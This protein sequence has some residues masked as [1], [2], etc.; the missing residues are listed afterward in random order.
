M[1][2][3]INTATP[4]Q[5]VS[6]MRSGVFVSVT[7]LWAD[8]DTRLQP[9][10]VTVQ[11]TEHEVE[12]FGNWVIGITYTGVTDSH[13]PSTVV[14]SMWTNKPD[15]HAHEMMVSRMID[16]IRSHY[17]LSVISKIVRHDCVAP[18]SVMWEPGESD[19]VVS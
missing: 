14:V 12:Q 6:M 8:I 17:N 7:T 19:E 9:V 13:N 11:Q 2:Q 4:A 3:N 10:P 5:L 1:A 18:M 15:E 16:T